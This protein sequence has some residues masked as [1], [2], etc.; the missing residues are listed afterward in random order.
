MSVV[1]LFLIS[2]FILEE[3]RANLLRVRDF[4]CPDRFTN[5]VERQ[6][7]RIAT[8]HG[9]EHAGSEQPAFTATEP[10]CVGAFRSNRHRG[11]RLAAG[12]T[13]PWASRGLLGH[14]HNLDY[15]AVEA[16]GRVGDIRTAL[17][18]NRGWSS[19]RCSS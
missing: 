7:F 10:A 15:H 19:D 13:H 3:R 17:R 9:R 11:G 2:Y 14:H 1:E 18:R 8:P 4:V 6:S 5:S 12:R 16:G